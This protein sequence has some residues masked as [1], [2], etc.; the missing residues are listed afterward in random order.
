M[1]S[2]IELPVVVIGGGVLG[3]VSAWKLAGKYERQKDT[4][5]L[6][7]KNACLGEE[8]TTHSSGVNHADIYY[9]PGTLKSRLCVLG[10]RKSKEFFLRHGVPYHSAIGGKMVVAVTP[11]DESILEFYLQRAKENGVPHV[12]IIPGH[13]IPS[14]EPNVRGRSALL[15]PTSGVFDA[16]TYVNRLEQLAVDAGVTIIKNAEIVGINPSTA[17]GFEVSVVERNERYCFRTYNLVNAA[18]LYA[19]KIAKM[20]NPENPYEIQPLRGEYYTFNKLKRPELYLRGMN[21]YTTPKYAERDGHEYFSVGIHLTPTF[22]LDADRKPVIGR[23]VLVGPT[24]DP[25]D[26]LTDYK[27]FI[28]G[29][30]HFA[31]AMACIIPGLRADDLEK[32]YIGIR[33][34]LKLPKDDF[35]IERDKM[36]PGLRHVMADSPGLTCATVIGDYVRDE[37]FS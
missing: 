23:T 10:N 15:A 33:A 16:A 34:K 9:P 31:D 18:G 22:E 30:E 14:F 11:E 27:T 37:L 36:F 20:V 12:Q 6:F 17:H 1:N 24:A 2:R 29:P 4:V 13:E 8:Q 19:P 25:C 35:I 21:V 3:A 5:Y 28:H 26:S 7:E 32:G